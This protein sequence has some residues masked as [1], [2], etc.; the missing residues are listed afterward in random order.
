M[1]V[2]T[3]EPDPLLLPAGKD[4]RPVVRHSIQPVRVDELQEVD[5]R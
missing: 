1:E 5:A 4:V 2:Q 3:R